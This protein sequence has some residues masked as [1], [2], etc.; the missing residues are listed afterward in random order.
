MRVLLD[1]SLKI[2]RRKENPAANLNKGNFLAAYLAPQ[3]VWGNVKK[4]CGLVIVHELFH[5]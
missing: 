1:K 2:R 3:R 5:N 4:A